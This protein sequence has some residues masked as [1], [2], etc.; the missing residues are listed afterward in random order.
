MGVLR[1]LLFI[2]CPPH[3]HSFSNRFLQFHILSLLS[4]SC[5]PFGNETTLIELQLETS[6]SSMPSGQ[7]QRSIFLH[8]FTSN[9]LRDVRRLLLQLSSSSFSPILTKL[10]QLI[11]TNVLSFTR[12][13]LASASNFT[14]YLISL[15]LTM[16][17]SST[18]PR[19]SITPLHTTSLSPEIP[20]ISNLVTAEATSTNL[21]NTPLSHLL[22]LR[23]FNE[24]IASS[25]TSTKLGQPFISSFCKRG[26]TA[27]DHFFH[28]CIPR[29]VSFSSEG[30]A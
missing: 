4:F 1:L 26:N 25:V 9:I 20:F 11:T 10:S 7:L 15:Q 5:P 22:M 14:R 12:I 23:S 16:L 27:P 21:L 13:L 18:A 28:Q 6:N 2:F 3:S 29:K 17:N 8:S 30:N 24:G 19:Y